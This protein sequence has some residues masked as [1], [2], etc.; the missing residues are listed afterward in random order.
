[1]LIFCIT[2][3]NHMYRKVIQCL[4]FSSKIRNF[5]SFCVMIYT[6][7]ETFDVT[8]NSIKQSMEKL[9]SYL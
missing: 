5:L 1:M 9:T 4:D 6:I 3:L 7:F 2:L 8:E